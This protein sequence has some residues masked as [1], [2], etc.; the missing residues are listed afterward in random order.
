MAPLPI[1]PFLRKGLPLV[2]E[3]Y[4]YVDEFLGFNHND[5]SDSHA[6]L[7]VAVPDYRARI[8][9]IIFQEG[10]ALVTIETGAAKAADLQLR[11]S[12]RHLDKWSEISPTKKTNGFFLPMPTIPHQLHAFLTVGKEEEVVDRASL[13]VSYEKPHR[14]ISFA[15]P[16]Q[17]IVELIAG[18]ENDRVE[19]KRHLETPFPLVQSVCAFANTAGGSIFVGVND[20][21]TVEGTEPEKVQPKIQEWVERLSDP[22]AAL[23]FSTHV[24]DGRKILVVE[25]PE[26]T[27]KPYVHRDRGA[28]Y[29]RRGA[30]DRPANRAEI[31]AI[32]AKRTG[33][34]SRIGRSSW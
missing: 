33:G 9:K 10:G 30:T 25:V 7:L 4:S 8:D 11:A 31:D 20:D 24:L 12:A 34:R 22:P 28:I 2:S 17:Q 21:G 32:T 3:A 23:A 29:V 16:E 5:L 18:G 19:F 6:G 26:G 27:N 15:F 13:H 1:G 14:Q